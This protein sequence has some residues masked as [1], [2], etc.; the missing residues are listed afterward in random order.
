M[1]PTPENE[2]ALKAKQAEEQVKAMRED[3]KSRI[4]GTPSSPQAPVAPDLSQVRR[5]DPRSRYNIPGL[6]F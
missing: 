1:L 3:I 4:F 2:E 5:S 6:R